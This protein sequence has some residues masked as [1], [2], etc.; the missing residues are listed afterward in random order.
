MLLVNVI[1]QD[2][3]YDHFSIEDT[4]NLL[5]ALGRKLPDGCWRHRCRPNWIFEFDRL[6]KAGRPKIGNLSA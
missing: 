1:R 3:N 4:R 2:D 6:I 5:K